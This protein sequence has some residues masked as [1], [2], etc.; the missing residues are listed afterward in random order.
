MINITGS[1]TSYHA[2]LAGDLTLSTLT[3]MITSTIPASEF[4]AWIPP[5][6]LGGL[7][8]YRSPSPGRSQT[9]WRPLWAASEK[10]IMVVAL[11]NKPGSTLTE[12][13]DHTLLTH[14]DREYAVTAMMTYTGILSVRIREGRFRNKEP[15][16][17]MMIPDLRLVNFREFDLLKKVY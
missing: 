17:E 13:S 8:S 10:G 15:I 16:N 7:P 5:R 14:A 2:G 9:F 4:E 3:G 1:R 12:I 6:S 11:T